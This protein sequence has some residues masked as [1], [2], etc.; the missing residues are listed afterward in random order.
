M[1]T[2]KVR[3][4]RTVSIIW[5]LPLIALAI[6]AW[7]LYSSRRDAGIEITIHFGDATGSV[8]GKTQV[9]ARGIPVGLV[10]RM[11][12]D[13]KNKQIAATVRM[14]KAVADQLVDDTLFWVV[15]PELSASSIHGL[16][17]IL[18]GSYIGIQVGSSTTPRRE[19]AGLNSMPPVSPDTPGLHLKLQAEELGSIQVGTGIYYRNIQIGEVQKYQLQGDKNVSIELF[20]QPQFA[21]LVREGSRFCNAS[22][23]HISGKLP[24]L[25]VHVESLASLLRGG[26]LLHTPEQLQTTPVARN[27]HVFNLYPDLEAAEYGIPMTLTLASSEDIVKGSTKV[28]YRGAEVG[29]VKDI[30]FNNDLERTVTAHVLLDPRAEVILRS[31]TRFWLVKPEI[32]PSGI[33]N[34]QLLLSGT[35]ITFQAGDGDFQDHFEIVS[36]P[37]PQVPLRPGQLISLKA[38]FPPELSANSPVYFKNLQVG[39]VVDVRLEGPGADIRVDLYIYREFLDYL[40]KKS[41]FWVESGVEMRGSL[42][43]GVSVATGPLAR[44][45]HGGVS[46]LT[47]DLG[48][49]TRPAPPLRDQVYTLHRNSREAAAA[50]PELRPPGR[51]LTLRATEAESLSVGAPLLYKKVP[52]GE[53]EG[54]RLAADGREVLVDVLVHPQHQRLI[55]ERTRFYNISGVQLSGGLDGISL[56]SGSLQSILAGG[57]GCTNPDGEPWA[58]AVEPFPLYADLHLALHADEAELTVLLGEGRG[59]KVGSPLR[60]HGIDIGKV[61]S[62][63]LDAGGK[64]AATVH[65]PARHKGLLRRHSKIWV[66]E[67]ELSLAGIKNAETVIFG[68]YLNLLP[69]G[70]EE[71]L[72]FT[73]LDEPPRAELAR[74]GGLPLVLFADRLGSLDIG[75]PLYYRQVPIGEVVAYDLAPSMQKVRVHVL[76]KSRYRWAVRENS[77]FWQVSGTRIEGGIFSG[78]TVAAES[79]TAI[80]RGGI[81]LATPEEGSG[82]VVPPEASFIL[83]DRAEEEWLGWRPDLR[84]EEEQ[85]LREGV[86]ITR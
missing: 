11:Q 35:Q 49:K 82:A 86:E 3:K 23:I 46:F 45:L 69:G 24:A 79:L 8:P 76:V 42:A 47:P 70:G 68:S 57:I 52:I 17:T 29:F 50:A 73:A 80:I 28:V 75:S 78:V 9:M 71:T 44:M 56:R 37:P 65:V 66:E 58:A 10:T 81:A 19:F 27:G 32:S 34:L 84:P 33:D 74:G 15:R 20:I 83:H 40:G 62:L 5:I 30:A 16:D 43:E 64:V 22:G 6:S 60:H 77:R 67:A 18:S 21:H 1:T 26:I 4:N 53:V 39:E 14:D 36:Q 55:G 72:R 7:L 63:R 31:G 12:P 51:R 25:K 54:F 85:A 2:A 61:S 38:D 13:L 41:L 59:L 48:G